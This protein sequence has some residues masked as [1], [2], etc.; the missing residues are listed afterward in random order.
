MPCAIEKI[1]FLLYPTYLYLI[2]DV[3]YYWN[4]YQACHYPIQLFLLLTYCLI[5]IHRSVTIIKSNA[6]LSRSGKKI[7]TGLSY[8][9]L[10]PAFLYLTVQGI[11]W[12]RLNIEL[13]P[14]CIPEERVPW[15]VWWW[16][17]LLILIDILLIS[18][19][20]FRIMKWWRMRRFRRRM[21]TIVSE[22]LILDPDTLS[23][24]LL[25]I[26]E[27]RLP[28]NINEQTGLTE[29]EISKI[30]KK[31][32]KQNYLS[33]LQKGREFCPICYD[34]IEE[35]QEVFQLPLCNHTFHEDCIRAW[36]I[37]NPVCPMCRANVKENLAKDTCLD[38]KE[39]LPINNELQE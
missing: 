28:F 35:G 11:I 34:D 15:L 30:S 9:I 37:K 31:T 1:D 36:L 17:A 20:V 7:L 27:E 8:W 10:N 39:R 38:I 14:Q 3:A 33:I 25:T 5:L 22:I 4:D 21:R 26:G 19:T 18:L 16:I 2:A 23:Q 13:S 12:Q 32:Y 6:S 24:L 29:E